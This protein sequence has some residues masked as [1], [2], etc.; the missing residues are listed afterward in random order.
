MS[1]P[2]APGAFI[3]TTCTPRG[4]PRRGMRCIDCPPK[5]RLSAT[6]SFPGGMQ[7]CVKCGESLGSGDRFCGVCGA[8]VPSALGS[9]P[10]SRWF[11]YLAAGATA[12]VAITVTLLLVRP[13]SDHG[14]VTTVAAVVTTSASATATEVL[15][16]TT[17]TPTTTTAYRAFSA[18]TQLYEP[19]A[20]LAQTVPAN[21]AGYA[22]DGSGCV[23]NADSLPDGIW[24]GYVRDI[25][26]TVS[27]ANH[28]LTFDMACLYSGNAAYAEAGFDNYQ[29]TGS[30]YIRNN[31]PRTF[32]ALVNANVL[33]HRLNES[34]SFEQSDFEAWR[35]PDSHYQ[36]CP[37]NNCRVWLYVNDGEVTEIV[38]QYFP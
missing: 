2:S 32:F 16:T 23:P 12:V 14:S 17:T 27:G 22:A 9:F 25:D 37:G 18:G 29:I 20:P 36:Q 33:V 6:T 3:A 10:S 26:V 31:T 19:P 30:L 11:P 7:R 5:P 34:A 13:G 24:F 8:A 38:E 4:C 1:A 15:T 28:T 35:A 21:Q